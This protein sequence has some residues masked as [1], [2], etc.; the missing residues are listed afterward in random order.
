VSAERCAERFDCGSDGESEL[1]VSVL[2]SGGR[3][4][5]EVSKY[6][7]CFGHAQGES[8]QRRDLLAAAPKRFDLLGQSTLSELFRELSSDFFKRAGTD[9]ERG[10]ERYPNGRHT[11]FSLFDA[12]SEVR[13]VG[14]PDQEPLCEVGVGVH[15]RGEAQG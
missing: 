10:E 15:D 14:G 9:R 5:V 12:G 1:A 3:D 11:R 7:G 13:N 2:A 8:W 6:F 4:G